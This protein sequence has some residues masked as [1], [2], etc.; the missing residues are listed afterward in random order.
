M[1]INGIFS[2]LGRLIIRETPE[3]KAIKNFQ[4]ALADLK[5]AKINI[6]N[7]GGRAAFA[8]TCQ[9]L[10][11][12]GRI[13]VIHHHQSKDART[14]F[15]GAVNELKCCW[16]SGISDALRNIPAEQ[17]VMHDF[18]QLLISVKAADGLMASPAAP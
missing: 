13:L 3:E 18:P 11:I 5:A 8:E 14:A 17:G 10:K 7:E 12:T 1:S 2:G 9:R 15:L 4:S 16:E 6:E